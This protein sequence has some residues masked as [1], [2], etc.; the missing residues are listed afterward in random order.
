MGVEARVMEERAM[1]NG[2][3][4]WLPGIGPDDRTAD[5]AVRSLCSRIG[6]VSSYL[7]LAATRA[8]EDR[9]YVHQLRVWTR[10]ATAALGLYEDL[11]PRRRYG[12]MKKQL[13]R[14]RRAANDARD[15]DVL[16]ERLKQKKVNAATLRWI[17][18]VLEERLEAQD[19]IIAVYKRLSKGRRF[20][21]RTDKLLERVRH[22]AEHTT[23][24]FGDWAS[25]RLHPVIERFFAAVPADRFDEPRLHQ[26]R[27]RGKEL[28]Y[29]I[30][31]LAGA[32]PEGLRTTH[33]PVIEE[34]QDRLGAINDLVTSKSRLRE[35]IKAANDKTEAAQWRRLLAKDQAQLDRARCQF[36]E[37]MTPELLAELRAGLE[38]MLDHKT[39]NPSPVSSS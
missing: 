16:L 8:A 17:N 12:W 15:C 35:K 9:E 11:L 21:R 36:W 38:Q 20:E 13:K 31:L 2:P 1:K 3:E 27:I 30:E 24:R 10:R 19:A 28:R 14:I 37:W 29:A 4:K 7:P 25:E 23:E 5:V 39:E 22:R 26:F 18:T 34:M 6:A 33:Y 32:F